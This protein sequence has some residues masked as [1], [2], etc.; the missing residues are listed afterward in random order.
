MVCPLREVPLYGIDLLSRWHIFC[1]DD[2]FLYDLML[3]KQH[4]PAGVRPTV[5]TLHQD[6]LYQKVRIH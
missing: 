6:D 1:H 4:M 2:G 5:N 3:L